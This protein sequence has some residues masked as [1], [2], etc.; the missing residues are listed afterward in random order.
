[1]SGTV[2]LGNIAGVAAAIAL[3]GPGASLWMIFAAFIG[4]AAKFCECTLA[5][6]YRNELPDV[7]VSGGPMYY[8]RMGIAAE[9]PRLKPLGVFL[10]A[11]FAVL[12]L[13]GTVGSGNFFQVNQAYHQVLAVTGGES[14]F[15]A[16]NA[17]WCSWRSWS[18]S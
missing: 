5:V 11:L 10:G 8:L 18:A 16:G 7:S 1:V 12:C 9:Y 6:K 14:S 17:F 4:M 13:V 15:L 2:G 3:G